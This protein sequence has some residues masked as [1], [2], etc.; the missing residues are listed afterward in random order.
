[1]WCLRATLALLLALTPAGCAGRGARAPLAIEQF[2]DVDF[3]FVTGHVVVA[4]KLA[5]SAT[6]ATGFPIGPAAVV[7]VGHAFAPSD[8]VVGH[9]A[10]AFGDAP[11]P[12]KGRVLVIGGHPGSPWKQGELVQLVRPDR[13]RGD[14][15][16]IRLRFPLRAWDRV[17]DPALRPTAG[18]RVVAGSRNG[19]DDDR[20]LRICDPPSPP[21]VIARAHRGV[22]PD[23]IFAEP[24]LPP[25][26]SGA[27]IKAR[28]AVPG[29]MGAD[30]WVTFGCLAF[31][32]QTGPLGRRYAVI[33]P[34]PADVQRYSD[35]T[36]MSDLP[37][38]LTTLQY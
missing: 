12:G 8:A 36:P 27:P 5:G 31:E 34:L 25:G 32:Y 26:W 38:R 22:P 6:D 11:L 37:T 21:D 7:T 2:P 1:V 19:R 28:R 23:A 14:F 24:S 35:L 29:R 18:E 30:E 15:A 10:L 16:L 13:E 3:G 20:V 9:R 33:V 4:R 17:I